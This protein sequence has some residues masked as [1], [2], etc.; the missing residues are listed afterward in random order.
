MAQWQTLNNPPV[1]VA[2]FQI[3]Y[4]MDNVKLDDFLKFDS[5]L[6]RDLTER[7]DAFQA[8]ISI[9]NT[10]SIP[11]G[12]SKVLGETDARRSGYEYFS[13]EQKRKLSINEGTITYIDETPYKGWDAFKGEILKYL[14]VLSPVLEKTTVQRTSI[15]FINQFKFDQFDDPEVYFNTLVTAKSE[16]GMFS[17][18]VLKYGFQMSF[19]MGESVISHVKQLAEKLSE[20]VIYTFDIDVL[21][22]HNLIYNVDSI[23]ATLEKI[24]EYKNDIFFNNLTNEAL[25]LCD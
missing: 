10:T 1:V 15:R 24:R 5:I 7:N 25:K 13:K 12:K 11:L 2:M 20:K 21:D 23:D 6:R 22:Y 16:E 8:S 19:E 14:K 4:S 18:P 17:H 3:R 9:P